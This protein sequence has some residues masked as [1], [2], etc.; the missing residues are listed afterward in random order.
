MTIAI[1][2]HQVLNKLHMGPISSLKNIR[3]V[4]GEIITHRRW[5]S[6]RGMGT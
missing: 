3:S 1:I 6:I 2:I 4:L 5:L